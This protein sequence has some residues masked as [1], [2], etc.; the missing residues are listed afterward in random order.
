MPLCDADGDFNQTWKFSS[1]ATVGVANK[2][3]DATGI[4]SGNGTKSQLY[5][6]VRI[7][8]QLWT[9]D[10]VPASRLPGYDGSANAPGRRAT[11]A[12]G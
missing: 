2:V 4:S 10:P 6:G 12:H 8:N 1:T 5:D 9:F 11:G 7:D 3:L